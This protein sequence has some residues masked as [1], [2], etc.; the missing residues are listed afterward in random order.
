MKTVMTELRTKRDY[1]FIGEI[2][3]MSMI[4]V[5][6]RKSRKTKVGQI[7]KYKFILR[8]SVVYLL[9]MKKN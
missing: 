4:N 1:N 2:E 3:R 9:R 8:T 7:L 5:T 6:Y